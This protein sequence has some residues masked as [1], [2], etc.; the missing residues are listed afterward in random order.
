MDGKYIYDMVNSQINVKD[1][2]VYLSTLTQEQKILYTRYN[3]KV[4]QDK[5]KANEVNKTKYNDIRKEHIKELRINNPEKMKA[6]NIKDVRNFREKEKSIL[7]GI[8][9]KE[10]ALNT[11]TNAIRARKSRKEIDILKELKLNDDNNKQ[12][13]MSK[14]TD[15]IRNK[16]A[17]QEM[18]QLKTLKQEENK[19]VIPKKLTKEERKQNTLAKKREYMRKYRA[20]Q[21]L[22]KDKKNR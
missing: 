22:K 19:P 16:K 7:K 9:D 20:E 1:R 15:A 13:L 2:R 18:K 10:N 17:R 4:R 5:F 11:L 6:Q 14:I 8:K 21:K 3:N 12:N